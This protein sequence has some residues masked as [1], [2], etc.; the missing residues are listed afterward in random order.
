MEHRVV[1][2][3]LPEEDFNKIKEVLMDNQ[4]PWFLGKGVGVIGETSDIYLTHTFYDDGAPN[5]DFISLLNPI[6]MRLSPKEIIRIR[7]NLYTKKDHLIEHAK[8]VD[9][10]FSHKAFI[11]YLN[12]N[13]GFTRMPDG[14]I[15]DS[16]ANRG[17][18]FD[19]GQPHNSTN[20][21][22]ELIR[23]NLS[24]NYL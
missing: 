12:T 15:V 17:V 22:D 3:F 16:V 4:F 21:T 24:F 8:H 5:S 13:N 2:N 10:E 6:L 9:R 18:F 14:R 11:F 1:D 19:G 20:C 23:I 7:A